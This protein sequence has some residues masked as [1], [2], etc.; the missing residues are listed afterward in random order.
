VQSSSIRLRSCGGGITAWKGSNTTFANRYG[1]YIV[2]STVRKANAS[3]SPAIVGRCALGRPWNGQMRAIF[4]RTFLDDSILPA[5]YID[6]APAHYAANLTLQA[7]FENCG[8]GFNV[9]ARAAARFVRLLTR[10]QWAAYDSPARVFV[11]PDGVPG[12][13]SWVDYHA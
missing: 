1:I 3:L 11:T 9:S 10:P 12:D 7:E 2:D 6:W 8:P 13:D 4:A 5:G